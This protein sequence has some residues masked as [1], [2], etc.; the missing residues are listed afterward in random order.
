VRVR[1]EDGLG[2]AGTAPEI[3][4]QRDR[5]PSIHESLA[6]RDTSHAATRRL[7]TPS[8]YALYCGASNEGVRDADPPPPDARRSLAG[9][10][11][12]GGVNTMRMLMKVTVQNEGGNAA[13]KDGSIGKII[14]KFAEEHHPEAAYFTTENGERT[15]FFFLDVKD[16]TMMPTLAE[17][18]FIGLNA[19]VTFAPAMNPQDLKAGLEKL[20]L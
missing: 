1:G 11:G 3:R 16:S 5:G 19:R 15:A 12:K 4:E 9:R 6:L 8:Y 7:A 14:G 2:H 20:K 10:T 17:P 18:F 13:V